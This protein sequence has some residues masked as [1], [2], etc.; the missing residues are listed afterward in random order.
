[1]YL[2]APRG[3]KTAIIRTLSDARR[4]TSGG[5]KMKCELCE[6]SIS[7]GKTYFNVEIEYNE[8]YDTWFEGYS[9]CKECFEKYT[10]EELVSKI[11]NKRRENNVDN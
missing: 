5:D 6:K 8:P 9:I 2:V 1:M 10:K 11:E 3:R 7:K 4:G